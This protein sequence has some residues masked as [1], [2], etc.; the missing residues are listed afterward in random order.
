MLVCFPYSHTRLRVQHNTRHSLRPL[1]LEAH[2]VLQDSGEIAP[3]DRGGVRSCC[4]KTEPE[5]L[6]VVRTSER[7]AARSVVK[8]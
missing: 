5:K 3:R 6:D 8:K 7:L 4:L 1:S 2:E